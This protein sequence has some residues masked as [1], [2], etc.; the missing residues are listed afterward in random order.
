[1]CGEGDGDV[2]ISAAS[3]TYLKP[4]CEVTTLV[5]FFFFHC[6]GVGKALM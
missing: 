6:P 1:M 3:L 2:F 4:F 5:I